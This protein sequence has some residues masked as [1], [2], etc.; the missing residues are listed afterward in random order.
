MLV[1]NL[2][3]GGN[4][5]VIVAV[6]ARFSGAAFGIPHLLKLSLIHICTTLPAT[7]ITA[8]VSPM[9]LPTPKITPAKIPD[10]AAGTVTLKIV[11]TGVVPRDVYKRQAAPRRIWMSRCLQ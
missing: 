6:H 9:A 4:V 8:M 3:D 5:V 7:M 1:G 11:F 2:L 10:F